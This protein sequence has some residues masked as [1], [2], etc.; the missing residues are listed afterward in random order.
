MNWDFSNLDDWYQKT[1]KYPYHKNPSKYETVDMEFFVFGT[2]RVFDIITC[3]LCECNYLRCHSK[4]H[5][6]S[7]IH[8]RNILIYEYAYKHDK[9]L[10]KLLL[11]SFE[12]KMLI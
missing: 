2:D 10:Y 4:D 11:N 3:Q 6:K 9:K 7:K 5:N 1:K 12:N 8:Q